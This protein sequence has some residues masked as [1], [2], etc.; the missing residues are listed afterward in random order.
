MSADELMDLR[1]H[2]AGERWRAAE[3]DRAAASVHVPSPVVQPGRDPRRW[4]EL[5]SA[6]IVLGILVLGGVLLIRQRSD[7]GPSADTGSKFTI[8][9]TVWHLHQ[10]FGARGTVVGRSD[11]TLTIGADGRFTGSDGCNHIGGKVAVEA[12]ALRFSDVATTQR[13]CRPAVRIGAVDAT[14]TGSVRWI[15]AHGVLTLSKQGASSLSYGVAPLTRPAPDARGLRGIRWQ[16]ESIRFGRDSRPTAGSS[17]LQFSD[18]GFTAVHVCSF[19]QG[20]AQLANGTA[21]L[22]N[23]RSLPHSCPAPIDGTLR[24]G[25]LAQDRAVDAALTGRV[26]WSIAN[27][28]LTI[29]RS[30]V[31]TL[32]YRRP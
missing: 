29:T 15:V 7:V 8:V 24:A 13:A 10:V 9:G 11:A 2:E 28:R 14:L 19:T 16:L 12:T 30:G 21:V 31:G 4:A 18:H 25:E 32:V 3:L 22:S 5:L 1:L 20:D 23:H 26:S 6:A 17:T 27:G